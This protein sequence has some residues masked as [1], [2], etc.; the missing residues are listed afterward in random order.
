MFGGRGA[1]KELFDG[2]W[3]KV[4]GDKTL[5]AGV[6]NGVMDHDEDDDDEDGYEDELRWR[7][8]RRNF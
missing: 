5:A 1:W 6:Y 7:E 4:G 2:C 3:W 8:A